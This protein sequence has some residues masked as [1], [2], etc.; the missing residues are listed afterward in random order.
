MFHQEKLVAA[1]PAVHFAIDWLL[2]HYLYIAA[3]A[4]GVN[5]KQ[6]PLLPKTL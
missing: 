2:N 6:G 5:A 3:T 1:A 4:V